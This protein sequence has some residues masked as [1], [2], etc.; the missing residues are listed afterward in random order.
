MFFFFF[1]ILY[2]FGAD[3]SKL[4]RVAKVGF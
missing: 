4:V 2:F 1:F 3:G